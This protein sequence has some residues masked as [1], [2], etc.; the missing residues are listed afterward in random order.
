ML[1]LGILP[2]ESTINLL[3]LGG[4]LRCGSEDIGAGVLGDGELTGTQESETRIE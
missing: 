4:M 2:Q 3:G 1:S